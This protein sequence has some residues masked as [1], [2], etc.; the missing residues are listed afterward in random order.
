MA[1]PPVDDDA[2]RLGEWVE[3]GGGRVG[4]LRIGPSCG[5]RGAFATTAI[6][7]DELLLVVPATRLITPAVAAE[8]PAARFVHA[9]WSGVT[10]DHILLAAF[11]VHARRTADRWW[12]PYVATLPHALPDHP[13]FFSEAEL[14]P[15]RGTGFVAL[16][17]ARRERLVR[18]WEQLRGAADGFA[19]LECDEWLLARSLVTSRAFA[20]GPARAPTLVPIA[21]LLNHAPTPAADWDIAPDNGAFVLRAS[22]PVAPAVEVH[23]SYGAKSNARLLLHYG[24]VLP[25]NPVEDCVIDLGDAGAH[26]LVADAD[27]PAMQAMLAG[28]DLDRP[29]ALRR[30]AA[31]CRARLERLAAPGEPPDA[32][33]NAR[34]AAAIR[35][36]ERR[37]LRWWVERVDAMFESDMS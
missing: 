4:P 24:F 8:A 34:N 9:T 5:G 21:D 18:E 35:E 26:A 37:V 19:D 15:L 27:A 30:L 14:A 7:A 13:L 1:D 36:G 17:A 31:I 33:A 28:I 11:L 32:P 16:L 25:D 3:H 29:R 2:R 6:A 12:G 10:R 23:D 20:L 22:T